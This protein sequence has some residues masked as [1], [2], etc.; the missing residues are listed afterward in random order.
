MTTSQPAPTPKERRAAESVARM[1]PVFRA[2]YAR[3]VSERT[4]R[5]DEPASAVTRVEG[6]FCTLARHWGHIVPFA[7]PIGWLDAKLLTD[8]VLGSPGSQ[9]GVDSD[10]AW[11]AMRARLVHD[12][13][14]YRVILSLAMLA[15]TLLLILGAFLESTQFHRGPLPTTPSV[16]SVHAP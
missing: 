1:E 15:T 14:K 3:L 11:H 12:R 7:T 4:R 10:A 2:N 5:G 6:A 9:V 8:P 16:T 13:R